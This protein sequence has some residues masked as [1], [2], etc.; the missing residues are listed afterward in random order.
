M[1][2]MPAYPIARSWVGAILALLVLILDIV[3]I[4]LGQIELKPGLLIGGLALA[5]LV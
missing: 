1:Q 4:A 2:N 5:L 3:F